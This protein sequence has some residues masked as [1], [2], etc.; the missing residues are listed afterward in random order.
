MLTSGAMAGF[1]FIQCKRRRQ[2]HK[3][4]YL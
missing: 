3:V 4:D 1:R 2:Q